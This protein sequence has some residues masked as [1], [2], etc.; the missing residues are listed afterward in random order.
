MDVWLSQSGMRRPSRFSHPLRGAWEMVEF[1]I[2]MPLPPRGL[3]Q[4]A[5]PC[6][7][8]AAKRSQSSTQG[9]EAGSCAGPA[10][11]ALVG[12]VADLTVSHGDP[13]IRFGGFGN[14]SLTP[15]V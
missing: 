4:L 10:G 3:I 13:I 6:R 12:P 1:R 11:P 5:K 14:S 9:C 15:A 8:D 7:M 2:G